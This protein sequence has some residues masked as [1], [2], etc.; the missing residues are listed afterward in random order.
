MGR[1]AH[2]KDKLRQGFCSQMLPRLG[3][4]E[5]RLAHAIPSPSVSLCR[6]WHLRS[7]PPF[8]CAHNNLDIRMP[9]PPNGSSNLASK[10]ADTLLCW[11]RTLP[12][13]IL[14]VAIFLAG[15]LRSHIASLFARP[16]APAATVAAPARARHPRSS[17]DSDEPLVATTTTRTTIRKSA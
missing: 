1:A 13:W 15:A 11:L 17:S 9:Y 4:S 14:V 5:Q 10:C 2:A 12:L 7:F 3:P 6:R 8:P 16:A